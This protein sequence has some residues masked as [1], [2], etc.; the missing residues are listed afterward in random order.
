MVTPINS[1]T[2]SYKI[3]WIKIALS[4]KNIAPPNTHNIYYQIQFSNSYK[5]DERIIKQIVKD[6]IKCVKESDLLKITIYYKSHTINNLI[7]KNNL[8]HKSNPLKQTNIVYKY[9]CN[10][11]DCELQNSMLRSVWPL[12]PYLDD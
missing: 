5:T 10:F 3:T 7:S 12:P 4:S 8:S 2:A 9:K 11:G 1:S 6:K